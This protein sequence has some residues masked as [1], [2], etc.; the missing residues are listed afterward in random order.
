MAQMI[1]FPMSSLQVKTGSNKGKKKAQREKTQL[2]GQEL[3]QAGLLTSDQLE[4]ALREQSASGDRLGRILL[5]EG[6]ISQKELSDHLSVGDARASA[7]IELETAFQNT[8][9]DLVSRHSRC[10][11]VFV[12]ICATSLV[13]TCIAGSLIP[14]S[15]YVCGAAAF[16]GIYHQLQRRHYDMQAF[17]TRA[18]SSLLN[19]L[20]NCDSVPAIEAVMGQSSKFFAATRGV[21]TVPVSSGMG[22][23]EIVAEEEVGF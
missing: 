2:L 9:A 19:S 8:L 11:V 22:V 3:L 6:L 4:V 13:A 5:R 14:L 16:A 15:A 10:F 20:K 7:V 17:A 18:R 23:T 21:S 1:P 12:L